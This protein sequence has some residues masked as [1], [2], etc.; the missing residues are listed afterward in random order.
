MLLLAVVNLS[1]TIISMIKE[2]ILIYK[3]L[4][5]I[6]IGKINKVGAVKDCQIIKEKV[7]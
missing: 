6:I 7:I 1:L 2:G 5:N 3:K 4:K